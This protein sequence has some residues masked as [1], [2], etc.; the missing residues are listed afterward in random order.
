MADT[1]FMIAGLIH[2]KQRVLGKLG[3]FAENR[4]DDIRGCIAKTRKVVVTLETKNIVQDKQ[5]IFNRR[6]ITRHQ[7]S[8]K[9]YTSKIGTAVMVPLRFPPSVTNFD[10]SVN[11]KIL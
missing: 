10:V 6:T 11:V 9:T 1:A 4:F 3:A 8:S 7:V 2:W 5:R